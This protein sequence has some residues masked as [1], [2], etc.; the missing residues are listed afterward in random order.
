MDDAEIRRRLN[1]FVDEIFWGVK[2]IEEARALE[3]RI[4][5]FCEENH[6]TFEQEQIFAE[7]GA[8]EVLYMLTSAPDE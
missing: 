6:V 7:S 3:K 5:A 2:S 8:G 4:D 1:E